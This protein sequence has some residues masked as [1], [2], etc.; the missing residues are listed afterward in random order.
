M[1]LLESGQLFIVEEG[2]IKC[3]LDRWLNRVN[4]PSETAPKPHNNVAAKGDWALASWTLLVGV[5]T[6][7][8]WLGS[9]L[10]LACH[11]TVVW[12]LGA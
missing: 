1:C 9:L 5:L 10:A 12:L 11:K 4:P 6:C 2:K 7:A 8:L 3:C